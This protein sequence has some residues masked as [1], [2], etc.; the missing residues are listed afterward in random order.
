MPSTSLL[1]HGSP[2]MCLLD[3]KNTPNKVPPVTSGYVWQAYVIVWTLSQ[4]YNHA[5]AG[6]RTK[7]AEKPTLAPKMVTTKELF[8][9]CWGKIC[10]A[11]I[12]PYHTYRLHSCTAAVTTHSLSA[13]LGPHCLQGIS[14]IFD[15]AKYNA[16]HSMPVHCCHY[17][18]LNIVY[19]NYYRK[20]RCTE[21]A[22]PSKHF[23]SSKSLLLRANYDA[24]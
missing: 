2:A 4:R 7:S 8:M 14:G 23:I 21:L 22:K 6:S 1:Q 3:I 17:D 18:I 9:S 5:Y 19:A 15:D 16:C 20:A 12:I 11:C 10:C 13:T 24:C